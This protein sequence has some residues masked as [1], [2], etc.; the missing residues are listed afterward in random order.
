MALGEI[1]VNL[2]KTKGLSQE[3][4]AEEFNLTRQTI[5]KW[6]LN[7]SSPDINYLVQLSDFFGVSIDYLIKGEEA[8]PNANHDGKAVEKNTNSVDAYKWCFY[9][10]TVSIGVSMLGMIA[11][12]ICSAMS[13][14]HIVVD[15]YN[16]SY[17]GI[18]GFLMFTNTLWF[19][20]VLAVMFVV[21][22][23]LAAFGI[24]K[25]MKG[26]LATE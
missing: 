3:Q 26:K 4:L 5:S 15:E 21:G 7:Q 17:D 18:L 6:E 20:I 2:R 13:G 1:L 22:G 23:V 16:R 12:M 24:V 9:L 19:F 10:G 8:N 11:F 25:S 14:T